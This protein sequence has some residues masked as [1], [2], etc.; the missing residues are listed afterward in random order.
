MGYNKPAKMPHL[1]RLFRKAKLYPALFV[2]LDSG[3]DVECRKQ[4]PHCSPLVQDPERRTDNRI[5][6][7]FLSVL[8][9]KNQQ[10][11]LGRLG[12]LSRFRFCRQ[13]LT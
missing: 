13:R 8:I 1:E 10:G 2:P 6:L 11:G 4:D 5:I 3:I 7:Y 9:A 12:I